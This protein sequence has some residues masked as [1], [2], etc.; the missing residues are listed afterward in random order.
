MKRIAII[1]G[2][3]WDSNALKS[4]FTGG[5]PE[6]I[7]TQWGKAAVLI[8]PFDEREIVF[9]HRHVSP[10]CAKHLPPHRI[11]Y[12]ANIAAMKEL[13]VDLILA[14]SSVG[15]LHVDWPVGSFALIDQIIDFTNGRESTFHDAEAVH[16]DMTSPYDERGKVLLR[17]AASTRNI[18]L[19]ENATYICTN[20]PRFETPAEIRMFAKWG[21]DIV[22]MT[23]MPEAA[24]ARELQIP[25][26]AL[27]VIT[28]P[29]AGIDPTLRTHEEV[30]TEMKHAL[31]TLTSLILDAAKMA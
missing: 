4:T 18:S 27:A 13:D 1:G 28:N 23:G 19:H 2:T 9:M 25:Y 6:I 31:P 29:A 20:G 15:T 26:A 24:L 10:E 11:N 17:Q 7:P 21:A 5:S 8:C 12:R 14:S 16:I 30:H 3:G 22:G